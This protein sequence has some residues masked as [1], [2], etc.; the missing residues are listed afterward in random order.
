[1]GFPFKAFGS[2]ALNAL[3]FV[4]PIIHTVQTVRAGD[5]GPI[6]QQAVIDELSTVL[7]GLGQI[8]VFGNPTRLAATRQ[9]IDDIV[10][11]KNA[12]AAADAQGAA[13]AVTDTASVSTP[14]LPLD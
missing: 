4:V 1:M 2:L 3:Q 7:D 13:N 8:N 6:K 12:M 10:T 9:L 11:Y 5:P 14:S